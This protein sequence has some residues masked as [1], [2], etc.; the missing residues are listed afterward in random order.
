MSDCNL[1]IKVVDSNGVG[2][3]GA[4]VTVVRCILD[5][6]ID[7][8]FE[9]TQTTDAGG[10][11]SF[12]L[13]Q[14]ASVWLQC[15][16]VFEYDAPQGVKI[17]IPREYFHSAPP[18]VVRSANKADV[19]QA[20]LTDAASTGNS[21]RYIRTTNGAQTLL[22]AV[23]VDR[24]VVVVINVVTTFA[25]GDGA[26]PIFDIG[27]TGT[28]EKFKA[29]LNTGTAGDTLVFAGQLTA[30]KALLVTVTA[31]TGTTSTGAI[32]VTALA[33]PIT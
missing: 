5:G 16:Q 19:L 33:L 11:T 18:L 8:A 9:T 24:A 15:D 26:A 27:E 28:P 10:G 2:V 4:A 3:A 23:P 21:A 12:L 22:A 14:G 7:T 25:A 17:E 1:T 30:G 32:D 20:G 29:D 31:A 13:P 6:A